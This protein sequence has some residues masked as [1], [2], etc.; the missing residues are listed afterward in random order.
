MLREL[1]PLCEQ[2]LGDGTP[3]YVRSFEELGIPV[4]Y[5]IRGSRC[6]GC[7]SKLGDLKEREKVDD[8]RGRGALL[9]INLDLIRQDNPS[10]DSHHKIR[11]VTLHELAHYVER[12]RIPIERNELEDWPEPLRLAFEKLQ[13]KNFEVDEPDEPVEPLPWVGHGDD[14]IRACIHIQHR[15]AKL[16]HYYS[17]NAMHVAGNTYALSDPDL[18]RE[19]LGDEPQRLENLP[20]ADIWQHEPPATFETVWLHDTLPRPTA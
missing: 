2:I 4:D 13:A 16:G 12:L 19:A 8:W 15:A 1:E 11:A 3:V 7:H 6:Y 20:L 10:D 17:L 18:Y 14:F 9:K 5:R